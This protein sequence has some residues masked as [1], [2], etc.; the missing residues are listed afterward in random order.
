[1]Q[2]PA[3]LLAALLAATLPG[4]GFDVLDERADLDV[5]PA[6][7]QISGEVEIDLACRS[8]ALR[9][10]DLEAA[11]LT[12]SGVWSGDRALPFRTEG[13]RLIVTLDPPAR[14]GETRTLRVRYAGSPRKGMRFADDQVLT[15][16]NT[17][18]WLVSKSDPGDKATFTL[19]LTLPAAL[20]VAANGHP[21]SSEVLG[22]GRALHVWREDRPHSAYLF[23]FVAGRF[24]TVSIPEGKIELRFLAPHLAPDDLA[25]IFVRTGAM[26][27][28]FEAKAGVPFPSDRYTQ[29]LLPGGPAQEMA[30]MTL[31]DEDYGRDVLADPREDSL[32]AHE[33]SHQWWGNLL[34]CADWS[35]FWLNEGMATFMAA[36]WKEHAW[37]SDEY[38]RAMIIARQ[39]YGQ[40][41]AEGKDRSL[42]FTGWAKAD[43]M[44]GPVTYSKGA[45][46][47]HLLRRE[48]GDEAFWEGLRLYTQTAAAAGGVVRT[49]DLQKGME[50]ASGRDLNGFFDQWAYSIQPALK[51]RHRLENG[52]V[53]IDL[54]QKADKPWRIGMRVAVETD[55]ERVSRRVEL[56]KS[57]ETFRIPVEGHLLSVRIDDGAALPLP[58]EHERPWSMLLHQARREPDAAGRADAVLTLAKLCD[59]QAPPPECVRLPEVLRERQAE[60]PARIVRQIAE[61]TLQSLDGGKRNTP[62]R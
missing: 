48:L 1:L 38:E 33:L 27:R 16:F 10:V 24:Q 31:M 43:D 60:D 50:Q 52:T 46:V 5:R 25:T 58:V 4:A 45:L 14:Q 8:P 29:A 12:I 32:M 15:V 19:R 18:S 41:V 11:D 36:A 42:V 22:D 20:D 53:V 61:R 2:G 13:D 34:T 47:L 7:K 39:R 17:S 26:L 54:E 30:D 44:G 9:E 49:R 21:V 35:D 37:G 51:A 3:L 40:A 59:S 62:P 23:G 57:R 56:T 6:E 28:F 55:Q